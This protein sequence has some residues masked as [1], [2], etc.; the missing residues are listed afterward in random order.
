MMETV[1]GG[2]V[3]VEPLGVVEVVA[4]EV[5]P[6]LPETKNNRNNNNNNNK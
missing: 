5:D 4:L 1:V 6:Q 2:V 3:D